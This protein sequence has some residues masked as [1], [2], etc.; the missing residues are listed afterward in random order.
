MLQLSLWGQPRVLSEVL[1]MQALLGV[2]GSVAHASLI[3]ELGLQP[4]RVSLRKA[5]VDII[6]TVCPAARPCN[7]TAVLSEDSRPNQ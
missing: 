2:R 1:S 4:L 3:D 7:S 5:R 6:S